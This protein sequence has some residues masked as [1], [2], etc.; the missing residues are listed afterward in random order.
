MNEVR[1]PDQKYV[2]LRLN[3][4]LRFGYDILPPLGPR[5]H[6]RPVTLGVGGRLGGHSWG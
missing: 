3:D 4:V 1:V 2:T 6:G 5:G